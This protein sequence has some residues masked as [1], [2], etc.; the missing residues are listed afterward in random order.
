MTHGAKEERTKE[1]GFFKERRRLSAFEA[2]KVPVKRV[3]PQ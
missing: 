3:T 1:D 2:A